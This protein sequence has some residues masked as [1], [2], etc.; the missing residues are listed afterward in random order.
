MDLGTAMASGWSSGI[1]VYGVTALVGIAGRL[2]WIDAPAFVEQAWVIVIAMILFAAEFVIDK[3]ALIDSTWD[4]VH[5][6]IRPMVGAYLMSTAVDTD[7]TTIGLAV[8]GA[9]LALSSHSAKTATRL[10]VNTSPEPFSNVG[11]SLAEDGLV[12]AV[13]TLAIARPEIAVVITLVLF[14]LSIVIAIVLYRAARRVARSVRRRTAL[15][16]SGTP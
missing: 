2:D 6:A 15:G 14:V 13:M 1:S 10:V 4:A 16:P 7:L 5:T 11:V 9:V 12:L 8:G 3:I